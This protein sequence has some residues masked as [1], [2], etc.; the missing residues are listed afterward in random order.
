MTDKRK[1]RI[2]AH[3]QKTGMSYQASVN[4][5][6]QAPKV[7]AD[8]PLAKLLEDL[9]VPSCFAVT[10]RRVV[11]GRSATLE[12]ALAQ[13]RALAATPMFAAEAGATEMVISASE[14]RTLLAAGAANERTQIYRAFRDERQTT[15]SDRC[16]HCRRWVWL[17][18]TERDGNCVCGQGF[19]VTFQTHQDWNLS[20]GLRCMDCGV[21]FA[22][23]D[24]SKRQSPWHRVNDSQVRCASC[25]NECAPR[26]VRLE[27]D[28]I[29]KPF[30]RYSSEVPLEAVQQFVAETGLRA[31]W[32][33]AFMSSTGVVNGRRIDQWR[34]PLAE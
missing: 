6:E 34:L 24:P 4:Q 33:K 26:S 11:G 30:V 8:R 29:G 14:M 25:V 20:Q 15:L 16:R 12:I 32:P 21:A 31:D 22:L 7:S 23:A 27:E 9:G 10:V 28:E 2:R 18:T 17:G 3:M 13:A 1:Q 5:L 19:R